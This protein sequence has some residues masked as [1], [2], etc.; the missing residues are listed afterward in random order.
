MR[1]T[2]R[3]WKTGQP[4]PATFLNIKHAGIAARSDAYAGIAEERT[5]LRQVFQE[6][7]VAGTFILYDAAADQTTT[8]NGERAARRYVPASTFKIANSLI[9][10]EIGVV[11]DENE[12]IPYGGRSQ[13]FK[14]WEKDMS[15]RE[16]I[17]ASAVPIYQELARRIGLERY[18]QWLAR[19]DFGNRQTGAALETF[20]L[21]GPLEISAIEQARFVANLAQGKLDASARSQTITR[22]I[23][24]LEVKDG[25]ELYG[26]TGWQFSSTP[27]LGWWVGW[28]DRGGKITA[29]ALNIDIKTQQD[30]AKRVMI[31]KS[32]LAKLGIF[33]H[34][35][36]IEQSS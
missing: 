36:R 30:G 12:V 28:V 10:L 14:Q 8:V 19:L 3:F 21:E 27:Q 9:A 22:D 1:L 24:W 26:K 15:M 5:E 25:A 29:F 7:G 23:I 18:R 31:G 33:W 34:A 6:H 35:K 20:W 13:P 11:K 4:P 17:A 16:A 2:V 32:L